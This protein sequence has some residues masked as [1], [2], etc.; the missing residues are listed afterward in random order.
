MKHFFKDIKIGKKFCQRQQC[1]DSG[2]TLIE[3]TVA[4]FLI[5]VGIVGVF[6]V[7]PRII[8]FGDII[9]SR[10]QAIYLAQEGIEIVRNIRDTNW[11]EQRDDPDVSWDDA[12][13]PGYWEADYNDLDL[14]PYQGRYLKINGGFY[15]YD[16]LGKKTKFRRK[17]II[18]QPEPHVLKISVLVTWMER[19]KEYNVSVDGKLYEWR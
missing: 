5:T 4:I 10:L 16:D 14:T 9:S 2:L 3:L 7:I 15:N 8:V 1:W 6:A 13:K 12:L 18:E 11:L 17:I 19:G